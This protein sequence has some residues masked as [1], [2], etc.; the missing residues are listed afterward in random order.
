VAPLA[1]LPEAALLLRRLRS[2]EP[3][4][5]P[6]SPRPVRPQ[7]AEEAVDVERPSPSSSGTRGGIRLPP[8]A[9]RR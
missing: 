7:E 2:R 8:F 9:P 6:L 4:V 5:A 1:A 3:A